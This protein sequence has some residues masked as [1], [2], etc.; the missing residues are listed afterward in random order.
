MPLFICLWN[1]SSSAARAFSRNHL[2]LQQTPNCFQEAAAQVEYIMIWF[3]DVRS[4]CW[5][6][7]RIFIWCTAESAPSWQS[8]RMNWM[9]DIG[10]RVSAYGCVMSALH[11][12]HNCTTLSYTQSKAKCRDFPWWWKAFQSLC[13]FNRHFLTWSS[14]AH[15]WSKRIHLAHWYHCSLEWALQPHQILL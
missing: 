6:P 8:N 2:H 10:R 15:E 1:T 4:N 13:C 3:S 14:S 12:W 9:R 5:H 11:V 7:H